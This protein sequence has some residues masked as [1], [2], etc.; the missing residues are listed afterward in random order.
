MDSP[1][2]PPAR[3][4]LNFRQGPLTSAIEKISRW[5]VSRA[6]TCTSSWSS[7]PWRSAC[8]C[9]VRSRPLVI[10]RISIDIVNSRQLIFVR[11]LRS[12]MSSFTQSTEKRFTSGRFRSPFSRLRWFNLLVLANTSDAG[13]KDTYLVDSSHPKMDVLPY[14]SRRAIWT[15]WLSP[16]QSKPIPA[17]N[18][19]PKSRIPNPKTQ[20]TDP[21]GVQHSLDPVLSLRYTMRH[22]L[23]LQLPPDPPRHLFPSAEG[24]TISGFIT[25]YLDTTI[26]LVQLPA[27]D[28]SH[29]IRI[30]T[31]RSSRQLISFSEE[32]SAPEL[33]PQ[34]TFSSQKTILT[35]ILVG[36]PI[37]IDSIVVWHQSFRPTAQGEEALTV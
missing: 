4:P 30:Y 31:L 11:A 22:D 14:D 25:P 24:S 32:R 1:A 9:R 6:C 8:A 3:C 15:R 21:E 7:T 2:P 28:G 29:T 36:C 27:D 10:H 5:D 37:S 18:P 17:V 13:L 16:I 26:F 33:F 34:K 12:E 35:H 19:R 23:S 20:T